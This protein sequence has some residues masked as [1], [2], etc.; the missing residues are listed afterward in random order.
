[1]QVYLAIFRPVRR[2]AI[3]KVI[4]S[5]SHEKN[6]ERVTLTIETCAI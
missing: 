5:R 4:Q 3:K 6:S 2:H 1:M